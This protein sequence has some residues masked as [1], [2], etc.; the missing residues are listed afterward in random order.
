MAHVPSRLFFLETH[1]ALNVQGTD[2]LFGVQHQEG[3]HEPFAQRALGILKNRPADN[4]EP[5]AVA[6]VA[7]DDLASPFVHGLRA[8]LANPVVRA[9]RNVKH[10]CAAALRAAHAVRLAFRLQIFLARRFVGELLQQVFERHETNASGFLVWCQL[11]ENHLF[12]EG[13]SWTIQSITCGG[14]ATLACTSAASSR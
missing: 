11:G 12:F 5:K 6:L 7:S 10:L 2:S 3:N 1:N 4:T 9:V 14:A 8:A 13:R